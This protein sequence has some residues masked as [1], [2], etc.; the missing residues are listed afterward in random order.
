MEKRWLYVNAASA[1]RE[2]SRV[3]KTIS[4]PSTFRKERAAIKLLERPLSELHLYVSHS[5]N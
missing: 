1:L 4:L 5:V 3:V 2:E